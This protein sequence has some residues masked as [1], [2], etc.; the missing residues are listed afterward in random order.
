[1]LNVSVLTQLLGGTCGEIP[2][3]L[4]LPGQYQNRKK[5]NEN[6][7]MDEEDAVQ[8]LKLLNSF[9][10][11]MAART[12][13]F[14]II[15]ESGTLPTREHSSNSGSLHSPRSVR[16]STR[17]ACDRVTSALRPIEKG[18]AQPQPSGWVSRYRMRSYDVK[19][20]LR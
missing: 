20:G 6:G 19:T 8:Y 7:G 4:I 10:R 13:R 18:L 5:R 16:D 17:D 3:I 11:S 14:S 1:M 15:A 2:I 12:D 9:V